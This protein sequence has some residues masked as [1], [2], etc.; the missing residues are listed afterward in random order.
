MLDQARADAAAAL[1]AAGVSVV[2][3]HD[4]AGAAELVSVFDRIWG[5][6]G[7]AGGDVGMVVALAHSGNYVILARQG[8][9]SVAG[10]VGFFGPP[11]AAMLHSHVVGV[12]TD[13]IGSGLGRAVKLHQRAWCLERGVTTMSWTVDPLIARNAWFN[14]RRLGARVVS[15]LPDLYGAMPDTVNV[16]HPSDRLYVHW[17]LR[18]PLPP[19]DGPGRPSGGSV[20]RVEVPPDIETMRAGDPEEA[21][22]WRHRVR[23]ELAP[24]LADGWQVVGFE[25]PGAYV[26]AERMG[27]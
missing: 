18:A 27:P 11:G 23:A 9:R 15:Y 6:P 13:R 4:A 20:R 14:L 3:V 12:L 10:G 26:V 1:A 19:A 16:G 7:Q 17:D 22:R 24:L 8:G 21:L 25:R 5:G 2:E